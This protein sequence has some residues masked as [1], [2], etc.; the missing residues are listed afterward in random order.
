MLQQQKRNQFG[1]MNNLDIAA[2]RLRKPLPKPVSMESSC[3][4]LLHIRAENSFNL[5]LKLQTS[6]TGGFFLSS[7]LLKYMA[8]PV[9]SCFICLFPVSKKILGRFEAW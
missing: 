4:I 1:L 9:L 8:L 5:L 7:M 6:G 3:T 2:A